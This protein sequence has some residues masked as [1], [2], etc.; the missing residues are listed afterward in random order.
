MSANNSILAICAK[1]FRRCSSGLQ[2]GFTFFGSAAAIGVTF[3]TACKGSSVG[4]SKMAMSNMTFS[5]VRFVSPVPAQKSGL[6][7]VQR[8]SGPRV[9]G[10]KKPPTS[11]LSERVA[12]FQAGKAGEIVIS[13]DPFASVLDC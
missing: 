3:S 13:A 1:S 8:I 5:S 10:L 11:P 7:E 12:L 9:S 6:Y 2:I 4:S